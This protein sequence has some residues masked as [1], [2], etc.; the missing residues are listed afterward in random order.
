[1]QVLCSQLGSSRLSRPPPLS[2]RPSPQLACPESCLGL[3]LVSC[4]TVSYTL[5]CYYGVSLYVWNSEIVN[6]GSK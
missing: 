3:R 4:H 1:M 2:L 6:Q 5:A